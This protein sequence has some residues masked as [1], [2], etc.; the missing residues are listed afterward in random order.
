MSDEQQVTTEPQDEPKL[1]GDI[2]E[3]VLDALG[4]KQIANLISRVTTKPCNC[5]A[6]KQTLNTIHNNAIATRQRIKDMIRNRGTV[7]E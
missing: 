6:R 1:L 5:G 7:D 2:V 4:G 3:D